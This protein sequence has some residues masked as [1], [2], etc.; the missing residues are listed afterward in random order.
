MSSG[1]F[2]YVE[3][4]FCV[5]GVRSEKKKKSYQNSNFRHCVSKSLSL[6]CIFSPFHGTGIFLYPLK[7]SENH[8]FLMFSGGI[9]RDK[10]Y[11]MV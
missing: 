9:E 11:E 4:T 3:F 7:I 2:K 6:I 8:R 10:R 1:R 5:Q